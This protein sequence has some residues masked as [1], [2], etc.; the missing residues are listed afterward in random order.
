ML[1]QMTF[2]VNVHLTSISPLTFEVVCWCTVQ[3][4]L[5]LKLVQM[6]YTA[7]LMMNNQSIHWFLS[8]QSR[9][10]S[11]LLAIITVHIYVY[12]A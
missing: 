7:K 8:R 11:R 1:L 4:I 2:H 12:Y 6:L 10:G 3:V 5:G 9:L